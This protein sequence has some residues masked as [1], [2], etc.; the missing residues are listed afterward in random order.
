MDETT[1]EYFI[2]SAECREVKAFDGTVL[3]AGGEAIWLGYSEGYPACQTNKSAAHKF[4]TAEE[5]RTIAAQWDGMPWMYSLKPG[6][7]RVYRVS[8]RRTVERTEVEEPEQ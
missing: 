8:E 5:I 3:T 6:T 4:K 2:A 7:L 1:Q